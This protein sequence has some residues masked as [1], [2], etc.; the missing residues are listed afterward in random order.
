MET[1]K[2]TH[3]ASGK[4]KVVGVGQADAYA[5][6][7]FVP[8]GEEPKSDPKPKRRSAKTKAK[9]ETEQGTEAAD[10]GSEST[11]ESDAP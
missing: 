11:N 9:S 6:R 8:D 2:L 5:A 3:P 10:T 7:G 1:V 4:S